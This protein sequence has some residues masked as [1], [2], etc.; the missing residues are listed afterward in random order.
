MC[1]YAETFH[2]N[3]VCKLGIVAFIHLNF[4]VFKIVICSILFKVC[5]NFPVFKIDICSILF[6][7]YLEKIKALHTS[8]FYMKMINFKIILHMTCDK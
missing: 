5:D 3:K 7:R 6:K 8:T 1:K 4:R 2:T